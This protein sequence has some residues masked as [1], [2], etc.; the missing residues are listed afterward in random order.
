MKVENDF[1]WLQC[2]FC[3]SGEMRLVGD[4]AYR[5]PVKFSTYV[6][7]LQKTPELHECLACSSW[8]TQNI[9]R[10]AAAFEMYC[11]GQSSEKWPRSVGFTEEKPANIIR[12]LDLYFAKGKRVLDI[13]CNTGVLL[14][15]ARS[16]GCITGGVEPSDVSR[17]ILAGKG[18]EAFN[19]MT[20]I[21]GK[22]DV[23][24]AFDVVEH[25]Y[26][27]PAFFRKS[28]DLLTEGGAVLFLTGDISSLSV[29]LSG[30]HWWYLKA[31]EHIVF[32]SRAFLKNVP[33]F[34][35]ASTD[36]TYASLAYKRA[37]PLGLAHYVRKLLFIGSYDGLPS[38][39]PDHML[40]ALRKAG[41]Q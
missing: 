21:V 36:A 17:G 10:E 40:V 16:R 31:P 34:E 2:P 5:R 33:D 30:R 28:A 7:A 15:Y 39:G 1:C 4:I 14:D 29:R 23:I 26:D 13:G 8:F 12:R 19:S 41:R 25:L 27:V 37:L 38:L 11:N 32:P 35:I 9:V 18:H 20:N 22:Y 6:I 3:Q 24:T